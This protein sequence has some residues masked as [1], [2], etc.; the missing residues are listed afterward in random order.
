M[1]NFWWT[2]KQCLKV[3]SQYFAHPISNFP[4]MP[5]N[6]LSFI[7]VAESNNFREWQ[8]RDS[9]N[10]CG[11][12]QTERFKIIGRLSYCWI[13]ACICAEC[14]CQQSLSWTRRNNVVLHILPDHAVHFALSFLALYYDP[15]INT[16]SFVSLGTNGPPLWDPVE[17]R[18]Q[19]HRKTCEFL[20]W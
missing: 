1:W 9:G 18:L 14:V 15:P 6:Y 7:F 19:Y 12:V 3:F 4:Q 13:Y 11:T 8:Y 2:K 16:Q 5:H 10:S 17:Y 20:R